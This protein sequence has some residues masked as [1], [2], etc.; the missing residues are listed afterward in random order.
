VNEREAVPGAGYYKNFKGTGYDYFD[1]RGYITV[2]A[3]NTLISLLGMIRISLATVTVV[4][5]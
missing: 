3:A 1:A 5:S 2:N 4:C